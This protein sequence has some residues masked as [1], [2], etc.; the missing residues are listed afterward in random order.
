[1]A[2]IKKTRARLAAAT[3]VAIFAGVAIFVYLFRTEK[4]DHPDLGEI[5]R[6]YRWGHLHEL[7][8]DSNR[9]GRINYRERYGGS[10]SSR[11]ADSRLLE[12]WEDRDFDG[13]FE[14]HAL[15]DGEV[16]SRIELDLDQ[17]GEYDQ[18][19]TGSQAARFFERFLPAGD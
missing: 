4:F 6:K 11:G 15:L 7:Y 18:V 10:S 14:I 8:A 3:L 1:M 17:D 16:V 13:I 2:G 19:L 9:D 5:Q 12:M